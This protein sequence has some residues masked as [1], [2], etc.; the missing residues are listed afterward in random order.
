VDSRSVLGRLGGE[1]F[2]ALVPGTTLGPAQ[3]LAH[4]VRQEFSALSM[5]TLTPGQRLSVSLGV[6][7]QGAGEGLFE[8]MRRAD[9][10]LYQA[11]RSGRDRVCVAN[12]P[13]EPSPMKPGETLPV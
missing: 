5:G 4:T 2:A 8:L 6:A 3:D 11:K 13:D 7:Q 12:A 1:E 10:A 9:G